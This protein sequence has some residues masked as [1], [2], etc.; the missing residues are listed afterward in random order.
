MQ[1]ATVRDQLQAAR[2]YT[3]TATD[4]N[5][6]IRDKKAKGLVK[7]S[8]ASQRAELLLERKA[9]GERGDKEALQR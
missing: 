3:L 9:A 5:H 7:K 2:D 4:I 6:I 8:L 1:A